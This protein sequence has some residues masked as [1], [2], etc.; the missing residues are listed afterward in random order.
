[1]KEDNFRNEE[2]FKQVLDLKDSEIKALLNSKQLKVDAEIEE[3]E[4]L[5]KI[6]DSLK[7]SET[8]I[9]E[10]RKIIKTKD[11]EI[12]KW[13]EDLASL[14]NLSNVN[15]KRSKS[16]LQ[17]ISKRNEHL[18]SENESLIKEL[19]AMKQN[20]VEDS[21]QTSVNILDQKI[22]ILENLRKNLV[23]EKDS[24]LRSEINLKRTIKELEERLKRQNVNFAQELDEKE[25]EIKAI[26]NK[27]RT[28]T[29][30]KLSPSRVEIELQNKVQELVGNLTNKQKLIDVLSRKNSLLQ[31]SLAQNSFSRQNELESGRR[32]INGSSFKKKLSQ[33]S[34]FKN[35]KN[36][37][38]VATSCDKY[39]FKL[40]RKMESPQ[41]RLAL[42]LYA[43]F[44]HI[45]LILS[46]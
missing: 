18:Q 4:I 1:M 45:L 20:R 28:F 38:K 35:D 36:L 43:L 24:L 11:N 30:Q 2:E 44:I 25:T 19:K 12:Y 3:D 40:R 15:M 5:T 22:S 42:I 29:N 37:F 6:T 7:K 31:Q 13:K 34:V 26:K 32:N 33:M 10:L 17:S 39:F 16:S 9:E 23:I 27:M 41:F 14:Q 46:F 21:N 8:E